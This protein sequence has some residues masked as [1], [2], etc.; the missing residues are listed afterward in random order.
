MV[1]PMGNSIAFFNQRCLKRILL[2]QPSLRV[3]MTRFWQSR[4]E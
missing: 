1:M 2:T 4:Q 3:S